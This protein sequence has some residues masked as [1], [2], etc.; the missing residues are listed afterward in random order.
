MIPSNLV[1]GTVDIL[2][3][4]DIL[5]PKYHMKVA[6]PVPRGRR[7]YGL[8]IPLVLSVCLLLLV[9][10]GSCREV[11]DGGELPSNTVAGTLGVP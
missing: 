11:R 9:V 4:H 8:N 2:A 1:D 7:D 10:S 3:G 6:V 5:A